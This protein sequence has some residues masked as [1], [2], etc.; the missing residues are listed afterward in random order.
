[1]GAERPALIGRGNEQ[2][3][4]DALLL[5]ARRG[6]SGGL[7][8]RGEPGIGKTSLL[9][10]A[11]GSAADFVVL[12]TLG[13]ESEADLA[14]SGLLELLRPV[15]GQ[16]P[17]IPPEQAAALSGA[18]TL[19][20]LDEVNRFAVCAATLSLLAATAE[21][22]P[23]LC[24]IDDAQWLD[25]SSSEALLFA[26]RRF[27]AEGIVM[28][29]AAREGEASHFEASG[30]PE[31][32]LTGL[33]PSDARQV[34][35]Q[36]PSGTVA[37]QVATRLVA[38]TEGNPLALTE[39]PAGLTAR[40]RA[41][42]EAL[43]VPLRGGAAIER[44][45]GKRIST[46]SPVAQRA[47]LI[48]AA[49]ETGDLAPILQALGN[50]ADGLDEAQ[51]AG[52]IRIE[53]D[54]VVFRH[55]LIRSAVY[56]TATAGHRRSAHA[57][58]AEALAVSN[59]ERAAWHR[60]LAT[61]GFDEDVAAE[62]ARVAEGERHRGG[63]DSQARLLE[64][65][66]R[67]TSNSKKRA[68]RLLEAGRAAYHAGQG[69]LAASM[70]E[71]GLEIS[72][73]PI[74]RADLVEARTEAAR[75]KGDIAT[76][77][78][79]CYVE[80]DLVEA[81]DR[82][83]ASNLV[84]QVWDYAADNLQCATGREIIDRLA[85]LQD[86]GGDSQ[87]M[88]AAAA[89]QAVLDGRISEARETA[90]RGA[91]LG[92]D[93]PTERTTDIAYVL[94]FVDE[95]DATRR[96]LEHIIARYRRE[97]SILDLV[98][99]TGALCHL[100]YSL[101]RFQQA[102]IAA[103]EFADLAEDAGLTFWLSLAL[104]VRALVEASLGAEA[105]CRAHAQR[106]SE[107][108]LRAG[109]LLADVTTRQALGRLELCIGHT[110]D[111]ISAL[112]PV[113]RSTAEVR[114]SGFQWWIPDLVEAYARAGRRAD[115]IELFNVFD[116]DARNAH[117]DWSLVAAARCNALLSGDDFRDAF[118]NAL[119]RCDNER[120]PFERA[121]CELVYGERLRRAGRRVEAR[122]QLRSAIEGFEQLGTLGFASRARHELRA[123][124]E[125]VRRRDPAVSNDLS[126]QELQIAML[127]A[128]GASNREVAAD[129]FLSPK[130]VE[131]HLSSVY[132]KL[133]VRSRTELV[134]RIPNP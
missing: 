2:A 12:R 54:R 4:I 31:L 105:E 129:L 132:R 62:L 42:A 1:M 121:R 18:L 126:A 134:R 79:R 91:A 14:Y 45:F 103:R 88:L 34:L 90:L 24:L 9:R 71:E 100:E 127:V 77:V 32:T 63:A 60:A 98:K 28:L 35:S 15:V 55:P 128:D 87:R 38:L 33:V 36:A 64:R 72:T 69:D 97:G 116:D 96:L 48:A 39:I 30:V 101:G 73:D 37:P 108:S 10:Y 80:A 57:A 41:G 76:W 109:S 75:I 117:H 23:V 17:R 95:Y 106:A 115:A 86:P 122:E 104:A 40:Q 125:T 29:F 46:M 53:G 22:R 7:V 113:R 56:G 20:T 11:L 70:L 61:T 6:Q 66:A 68:E 85:R 52:L 110:D 130:T 114:S 43:D 47:L 50:D 119:A 120:W 111:A 93:A 112:E 51:G 25:R 16:I 83:R 99:A 26:T 58:I 118:S 59:D 67:L 131:K 92:Y 19:G 5:D 89:L 13:V 82:S 8:V 3:R 65:A 49:N 81:L 124:G 123:T 102:R 107:L 74:T 21:T 78:A 27:A 84:F 94:V 133:G 44:A